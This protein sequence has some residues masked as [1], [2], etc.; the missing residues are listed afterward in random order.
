M[1][2]KKNLLNSLQALNNRKVK[3]DVKVILTNE[4]PNTHALVF[5]HSSLHAG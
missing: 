2:E 4:F 5:H 1:N 3:L